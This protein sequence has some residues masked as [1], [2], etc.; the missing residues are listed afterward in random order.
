MQILYSYDDL[1]R[2]TKIKRYVDGVNDD[3]IMDHV[4]YDTESLLTQF[5]YGNDLQATF[6]Y[7]SKD[8]LS[9]LDIKNGST[10]YL[11]LDYTY[12][13]NSNV[14]QVVNGWRD[15]DSNWHSETESY[16]YDGLDRLISAYCMS[17]SHT[18]AYDRAGNRT[19]KDSVTY[20]INTVNEVTALSDGTSFTYDSNGNRTQKT[21]GI[22]TWAY[23]Y[24]FA[25]RLTKM[26][27]NSAILGEYI[28]DGDGKRLQATENSG[29]TTYIYSGLNVLH[30]K[31]IT[32]AADY[33]YGPT[34]RLAKRITFSGES[35]TFYYHADHLGSTRL[36]TDEDRIISSAVT[37]HPFGEPCVEEGLEHYLFTEKE[38]DVTGLYYYG[39]RY[40]DPEL[41]R[42]LTRDPLKG[43]L[44]TPQRMNRYTYCLNNPLKLVDPW[45]EKSFYIDGGGEQEEPEVSGDP[46]YD[47]HGQITV[48]TP[49]GAVTIDLDTDENWSDVD[50]KA[51]QNHVK[52]KFKGLEKGREKYREH[53]AKKNRNIR[54]RYSLT[55]IGIGAG[56]STELAVA[57]E[58]LLGAA[59]LTTGLAV[60]YKGSV[61][62][63]CSLGGLLTIAFLGGSKSLTLLFL[64]GLAT[65]GIL[66]ITGAALIVVGVYLI[67]DAYE[68]QQQN[69]G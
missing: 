2:I 51:K 19:S 68:R 21:K 33:I 45:G 28:Y 35:H 17:W 48:S 41:G 49:M 30:E 64:V 67:H 69:T 10:S 53:Q 40:Y 27:K 34:G 6:T 29:A 39:A 47:G 8:R 31:N 46:S 60:A 61:W 7:D 11:D 58:A 16:S 4:N 23:T 1:N 55:G 25:D 37:Y 44:P 5:D 20:T 12:D 15:T 22:D 57:G 59:V 18:Y 13:T 14:T 66:L 24:D 50:D 38:K 62:A 3:I 26:E 43:E 63:G 32:G 36:T 9:T 54:K 65:G 56:A 42:F 52:E